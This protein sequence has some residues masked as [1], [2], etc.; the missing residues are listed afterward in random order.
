[1]G[2]KGVKI[3]QQGIFLIAVVSTGD[4]YWETMV[5]GAV[6]HDEWTNVGIR[7]AATVGL[8]VSGRRFLAVCYLLCVSFLSLLL[9]LSCLSRVC[10]GFSVSFCW[11]VFFCSFILCFVMLV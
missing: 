10:V 7:W 5:P 1:M 4:R 11:I 3:Y 8:E 9:F 6:P 2:H